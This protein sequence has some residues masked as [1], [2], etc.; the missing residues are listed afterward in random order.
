MLSLLEVGFLVEALPLALVRRFFLEAR[1]DVISSS[2]TAPSSRVP[3]D[4]IKMRFRP[5]LQLINAWFAARSE[6]RRSWVRGSDSGI[7][8]FKTSDKE[9]RTASTVSWADVR[10]G[11]YAAASAFAGADLLLDRKEES[12]AA[13]VDVAATACPMAASAIGAVRPRQEILV[14]TATTL[15]DPGLL[16]SVAAFSSSNA[17]G[18]SFSTSCATSAPSR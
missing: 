10:T 11:S 14:G 12:W 16:L 9:R 1:R 7:P 18:F 4:E 15:L 17:E 6:T 3:A 5:I 8:S 13:A 2:K